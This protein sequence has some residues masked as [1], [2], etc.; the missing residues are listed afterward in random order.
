[1]SAS[2][3]YFVYIIIFC[4]RF[5]A[6]LEISTILLFLFISNKIYAQYNFFINLMFFYFPI[7]LVTI[8]SN[9]IRKSWDKRFAV[10]SETQMLRCEIPL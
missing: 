2:S 7:L 9:F 5:V 4:I 1:M 3:N 6:F 10:K 8:D